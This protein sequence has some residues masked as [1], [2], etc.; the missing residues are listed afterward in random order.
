MVGYRRAIDPFCRPFADFSLLKPD[1]DGFRAFNTVRQALTVSG[2]VRHATKLAAERSGWPEPAFVLGHGEADSGSP[3]IAVGPRRFAYLPLPSI[4]N[5]GEGMAQV[6]GQVR[7]VIITSFSDN[8][9]AEIDWVRKALSGQEL[10]EK[11]KKQPVALLSLISST[12]KMVQNY[13]R[14][15]ST[16]A[17]VTPVVLPGYD[18]P[19]H[20][21]RRLKSRTGAEEQKQ[22]LGRLN[23]R[24]DGLIRKAIIHTGFS[25]ELANRAEIEWRKVGFWP[26]VDMAD[27]YGVPDHLKRF[28]RYHV[29]IRWCDANGHLIQ[30]P[31]PICIGGGRYY[32]IGLFAA[33][34][35]IQ[36]GK[37]T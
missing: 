10:V 16:W 6:I 32:G 19:A 28:P 7:R 18:D 33:L 2:M 29:K 9:K 12:E 36:N 37:G 1:A 35:D 24:I 8:C 4:E 30:V 15:A 5:R 22:L 27:R 11:D 26:G 31:G 14:S 3:Y 34:P 25:K 23:D 17:T 21:R 13:T 20:Y